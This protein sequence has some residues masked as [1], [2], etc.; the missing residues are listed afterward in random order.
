MGNPGDQI[1]PAIIVTDSAGALVQRPGPGVPARAGRGSCDTSAATPVDV[2]C[3]RRPVLR[4]TAS[5]VLP[6]HVE[7]RRN[8][9]RS[10]P[11]T[12]RESAAPVSCRPPAR[13]RIVCLSAGGKRMTR[14]AG[15]A[16][17]R[18]KK[19]IQCTEDTIGRSAPP[20]FVHP[21]LFPHP[22]TPLAPS[23]Y[24]PLTPHLFLS[25]VPRRPLA[26]VI[27]SFPPHPSPH[28]LSFLRT[29]HQLPQPG[30]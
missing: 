14:D 20:F 10:P 26:S 11:R 23:P 2:H 16:A 12:V 4:I 3:H 8:K 1:T 5:I 13:R 28:H 24:H 15:D 9:D 7:A 19:R 21:I 29:R 25:R 30:T 17:T 27:F 18:R 22:L 6:C